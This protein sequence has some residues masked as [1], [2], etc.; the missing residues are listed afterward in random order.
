MFP[1]KLQLTDIKNEEYEENSF[2][3]KIKDIKYEEVIPEAV[4]DYVHTVSLIEQELR[5]SLAIRTQFEEY[6]KS[7]E[8]RYRTEYRKACRINEIREPLKRSQDLYDNV[9]LANDGTFH[10][11]N[12][13]PS[14]FHNGVMQILADER[15]DIVWLLKGH[16]NE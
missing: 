3:R 6:E 4:D 11:Y 10:T 5:E 2:V 14:Y 16:K 9:T 8:R 15:D 1:D 7:V 13:V 12:S